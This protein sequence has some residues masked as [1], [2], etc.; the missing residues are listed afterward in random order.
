MSSKKSITGLVTALMKRKSVKE[1]LRAFI[2]SPASTFV[3]E[4]TS[5]GKSALT[6]GNNLINKLKSAPNSSI[7]FFAITGL[8]PPLIIRHKLL[9]AEITPESGCS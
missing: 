6:F 9:N 8:S 7:N 1:T 5:S 2:T 4:L 3:A